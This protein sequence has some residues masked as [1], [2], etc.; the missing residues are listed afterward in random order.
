MGHIKNSVQ[1]EKMKSACL[2]TASIHQKIS[3]ISL[4]GLTE[5]E[6]AEKIDELMQQ[7]GIV[8][9]S[10]PTIVGSGERALI[11]HAVPTEK[12]IA[13]NE[14]IVLDFGGKFEGYCADMTRTV[15]AGNKS[16]S[17]QREIYTIVLNA[18]NKA[19]ESVSMQQSLK[20][21]HKIAKSELIRGL[22]QTA[23]KGK[24]D[25]DVLFPHKTSHWIGKDVHEESPLGKLQSY[26]MLLQAGLTFTIEPGLYIQNTNT[27]YDGIGVR[28]E[29][30]VL[31]TQNGYEVLTCT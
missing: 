17:E 2:K 31:M 9:K 19:I 21:I 4:A 22:D 18:Q 12:V 23:L 20:S 26:E 5:I 3:R 29:D 24:Y 16:T 13:E 25:I 15:S 27:K 8:E 28:I 10:F 1:I 6:V 7:E 14:F 11:L 30:V